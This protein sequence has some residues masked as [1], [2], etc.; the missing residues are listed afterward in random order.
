MHCIIALCIDI[1]YSISTTDTTSEVRWGDPFPGLPFA[2]WLG[3][4]RVHCYFG[5]CFSIRLSGLESTALPS[6]KVVNV[7]V[8]CPL[9]AGFVLPITVD[10][11]YLI[12]M[13]YVVAV[14][15]VTVSEPVA[16]LCSLVQ[17]AL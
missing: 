4:L 15:F 3:L 11:S 17:F 12:P 14:L 7:Y 8:T 13:M 10:G 9:P 16:L 1:T 2:A 6:I 5:F